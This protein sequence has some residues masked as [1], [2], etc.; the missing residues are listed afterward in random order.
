MK[1]P[2]RHLSRTLCWS[3][4]LASAILGSPLQAQQRSGSSLPIAVSA[5]EFYRQG[6]RFSERVSG[7]FSNLFNG[8]SRQQNQ[9]APQPQYAQPQPYQQAPAPAQ[10]RYSQPSQQQP[11]YREAPKTVSRSSAP[12]VTA[13]KTKSYAA[14]P[15]RST[16]SSVKVPAPAPKSKTKPVES[17]TPSGGVYTSS[18]RKVEDDYVAPKRKS[19]TKE[20]VVEAPKPSSYE[21]TYKPQAPSQPSPPPAGAGTTTSGVSPFAL[22]DNN[23]GTTLP[24]VPAPEPKKEEPVKPTTSSQPTVSAGQEFPTGSV[25]KKPGRVVSPYP[26]HNELDVR[27]LPSGSLALDP[28]TQKV[29]KVP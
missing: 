17:S 21:P 9:P 2:Y 12:A 13:P 5:D 16:K 3:V 20:T 25:G 11:I 22:T 7:F 27:G 18:K 8:G 28:T 10:P 24:S 29:F 15:S 19:S 26:P 1:P 6:D 23:P 4:I 14:A